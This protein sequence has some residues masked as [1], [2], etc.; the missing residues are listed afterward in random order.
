MYNFW[1]A[2]NRIGGSYD[3][4]LRQVYY[5][6]RFGN[7]DFQTKMFVVNI[8]NKFAMKF[9]MKIAACCH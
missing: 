7:S 3:I 9:V 8:Y 4:Y 1:L 6:S 2:K 5:R